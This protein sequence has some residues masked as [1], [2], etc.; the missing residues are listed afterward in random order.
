MIFRQF[1]FIQNLLLIVVCATYT[2]DKV[3]KLQIVSAQNFT[4][5]IEGI[6]LG[7]IGQQFGSIAACETGALFEL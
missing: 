7:T 5:L 3:E 6:L 4:Y 2:S 1:L